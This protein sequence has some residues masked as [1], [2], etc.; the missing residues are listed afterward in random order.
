MILYL[1]FGLL[2]VTPL[3]SAEGTTEVHIAK[4][5]NDG[6][7]LLNETTVDYEWMM[8]N[9]EVYGDGVTHYYH[10]GPIF[11]DYWNEVHPNETY[12]NR[13]PICVIWSEACLKEI[14]L[15]SRRTMDSA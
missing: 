7:T 5:A 6:I 12:D 9:L 3:V 15:R 8:L 10:Q 4:Y 14:R 11:E 13:N 1:S 2:F